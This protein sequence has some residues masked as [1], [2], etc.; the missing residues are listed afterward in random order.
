MLWAVMDLAVN[1]TLYPEHYMP[2]QRRS[3]LV[4]PFP[5]P[6]QLKSSYDILVRIALDWKAM[7]LYFAML[8]IKP[9]LWKRPIKILRIS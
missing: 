1:S 9:T 6:L 2:R 4:A 3:L 7:V 8:A 5:V